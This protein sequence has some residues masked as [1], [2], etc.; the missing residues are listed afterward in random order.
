MLCMKA[1]EPTNKSKETKP[2][3][4]DWAKEPVTVPASKAESKA[5]KPAKPAKAEKPKSSHRSK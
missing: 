5:T 1:A 4:I 2:T 3:S